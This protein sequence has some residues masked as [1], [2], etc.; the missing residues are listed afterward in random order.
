MRERVLALDRRLVVVVEIMNVHIAVTEA[1][2][3]R[4]VEVSDNLVDSQI[5][6]NAASLVALGIQS[7]PVVFPFALLNSLAPTKGPSH[8]SISFAYLVASV[9][10]ARLQCT[11][12]RVCA[13]AFTAV[14]W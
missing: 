1:P 5:T 8:S 11:F 3:W 6:L 14:I 7:F 2:T 10:A 13:E 9:A 12:R 4:D